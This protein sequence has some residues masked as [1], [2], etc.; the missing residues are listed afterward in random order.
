MKY[1]KIKE[2]INKFPEDEQARLSYNVDIEVHLSV[3]ELGDEPD[4]CDIELSFYD[5]KTETYLGKLF[6][7][8]QDGDLN[9]STPYSLDDKNLKN[10]S[11]GLIE[12]CELIV[13]DFLKEKYE[14]II[15]CV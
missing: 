8:F 7:D 4:F 9:I 12:T 14:K 1:S 13:L 11:D 5:A 6:I 3:E 10:L 15:S 2:I